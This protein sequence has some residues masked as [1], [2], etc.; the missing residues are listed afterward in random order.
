MDL[1]LFA[2]LQK[3]FYSNLNVLKKLHGLKSEEI[4]SFDLKDFLNIGLKE[5]EAEP[6]LSKKVLKEGE[7]EL[8][9]AEKNKISIIPFS[10]SDFPS[11]LKEIHYCPFAM[12]I[13]GEREVLSKPTISIVGTRNCSSYGKV[14]AESLSSELSKRGVVIVSGL[15]RGID[16][17]A[18]SSAIEKGETIAVL[19]SGI[20][21]IYPSENK[22][23]AEKIEEKG[24]II[25]EFPLGTKALPFH[26]PM[27]NRIISGLSYI[28]VVVE[29][30]DKSGALITAKWA[31]EQGRDVL[32]VPGPITSPLSKGTNLL[33]KQ[34]A[35]PVLS[36]E[37]VW[38]EIPVFLKERLP[39]K[40]E[41][42]RLEISPEEENILSLIPVDS[43]VTIDQLSI[44][45]GLPVYEIFPIL[46]QLE[47]K[48]L[49]IENPGKSYQKKIR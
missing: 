1:I 2:G 11:L 23:I 40:M 22:K 21:I 37:D 48:G 7:E 18:H 46:F 20:D 41:E 30:S 35:K 13:R 4:L 34:G 38:E 33:I 15:A 14:I 26:F 29:A 3:I 42:E 45:S 5:K 17:V 12:W 19:G 39:Q 6:I 16:T 44:S 36:W 31:L 43:D 28:T 32:S 8:K 27:R 47:L 25:S 24:A 10:S 49:I 9:K